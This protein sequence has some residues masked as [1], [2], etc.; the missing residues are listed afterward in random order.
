MEQEGEM[1]EVKAVW[2]V[3]DEIEVSAYRLQGL[4]HGLKQWAA[5]NSVVPVDPQAC[6][7]LQREELLF[8]A[9]VAG[10]EREATALVDCSLGLLRSNA[11]AEVLTM[12][13]SPDELIAQWG[14]E[15][16]EEDHA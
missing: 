5:A 3:A 15:D 9:L 6:A 16:E 12:P 1:K 4:T 7:R 10:I 13:D 11:N 8:H 14:G 2:Q